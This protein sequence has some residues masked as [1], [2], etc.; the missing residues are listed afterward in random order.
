MLLMK[1]D[2]EPMYRKYKVGDTVT[3]DIVLKI[4]D[5]YIIVIK[6]GTQ[7]DEKILYTLFNYESAYKLNSELQ[8]FD[9]FQSKIK[10]MQCKSLLNRVQFFKH[11]PSRVF[12]MLFQV[13]EQLF[14]GFLASENNIIDMSCVKALVES[15]ISLVKDEQYHLKKIMPLL[16][17]DFNL[18]T[19]S[20]NTTLYALQ[21]GHLL[22]LDLDELV[23]LGYAALL[24]DIGEKYIDSIVNKSGELDT[25][26]FELLRKHV[27]YTLD[28]LGENNI[29]DP[30]ILEAVQQ[31]HERYDGS[32]Y[33]KGLKERY[34]GL[35]ASIVGICDVFDA[36]TVERPYRRGYSSF[37][38]L[39]L[40]ITDP[41]MKKQFN[42]HYIKKLLITISAS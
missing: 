33:P 15:I 42:H 36:L 25:D 40:M 3:E 28:I 38:A 24:H 9:T 12:N 4:S 8:E 37:E 13:N 7:I 35:L 22:N 31:H 10:Q 32:G 14:K 6:S 11:D 16:R 41:Q 5:D 18:A 2:K 20:F 19:H 23:K 29:E 26:E 17:D 27:Q 30:I 1:I 39:K 21:L 34:I